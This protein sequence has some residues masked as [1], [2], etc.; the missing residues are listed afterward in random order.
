MARPV[1]REVVEWDEYTA[2]LEAVDFVEVRARVSGYLYEVHFQ[3][4][5][6][7]QAG[8]PLFVID[9]RPYEAAA[10]RAEAELGLAGARLEL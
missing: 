8:D 7:V 3:E 1:E 4:G 9:P 5:A 6:L 2:R 10:R